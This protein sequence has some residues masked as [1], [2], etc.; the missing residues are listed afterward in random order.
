MIFAQFHGDPSRSCIALALCAPLLKSCGSHSFTAIKF[1]QIGVTT[2]DKR[3]QKLTLA[4]AKAYDVET[5][6]NLK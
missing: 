6:L 4:V 5:N 3:F 1:L 2:S